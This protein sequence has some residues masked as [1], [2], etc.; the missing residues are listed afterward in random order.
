MNT[1]TLFK[2]ELANAITHG[3]GALLAIA[4]LVI[5]IVFSS[6]HGTAWHIVSFSIYGTSMIILYVASTLY[7]SLTS[8]RVKFLFRKF[9][10]MS[11]FLMIAGTYTPFCLTALSGW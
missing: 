3:I 10:H 6:L 4:A 1:R 8:E 9:D 2:E 5:L 7:H 11:I